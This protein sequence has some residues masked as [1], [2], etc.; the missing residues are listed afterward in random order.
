VFKDREQ[1][2]NSSNNADNNSSSRSFRE[3]KQHQTVQTVE[4]MDEM[5]YVVST[6]SALPMTKEFEPLLIVHAVERLLCLH[7]STV[8]A[9]ITAV[10][11]HGSYSK[12]TFQLQHW[13]D[14][15]QRKLL[16]SQKNSHRLS[17]FISILHT[18]TLLSLSEL[19][20]YLI[21]KYHIKDKKREEFDMRAST[22]LSFLNS[23][24]SVF[25]K[26]I[27]ASAG[28]NLIKNYKPF[29]ASMFDME[30]CSFAKLVSHLEHCLGTSMDASDDEEEQEVEE[31][32][33]EEES[34]E[35]ASE[36]EEGEEEEESEEVLAVKRKRSKEA[37]SERATKR[38]K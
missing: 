3:R 13:R 6:L 35:S 30:T 15:S 32:E 26:N 8:L 29:R 7:G 18:L 23:S 38:R 9:A 5:M 34:E 10:K 28:G 22:S 1:E 36:E 21:Q 16:D 11:N 20:D 4:T 31:E 12:K 14:V 24:K 2:S 33:E 27:V 37:R 25:N 19:S 17:D